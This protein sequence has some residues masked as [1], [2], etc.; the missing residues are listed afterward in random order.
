MSQQYV[1]QLGERDRVGRI[2]A[3]EAR[4]NA[5]M[6]SGR[7]TTS[8]KTKGNCNMSDPEFA[9]VWC[10]KCDQASTVEILLTLGERR[11]YCDD[12]AWLLRAP[13]GGV[14]TRKAN[15]AQTKERE[16]HRA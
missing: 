11:A 15:Q 4:V 13:R 10:C 12:H 8:L 5:R 6:R 7:L 1:P 2:M 14:Y 3:H 9:E 16:L